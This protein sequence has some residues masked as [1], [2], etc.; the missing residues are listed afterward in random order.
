LNAVFIE[1]Y[2]AKNYLSKLPHVLLFNVQGNP[3][4][5]KTTIERTQ[6]MVLNRGGKNLQL[7]SKK[8]D[9]NLWD[10]INSNTQ[11][12]RVDF[13]CRLS[14]PKTCFGAAIDAIEQI[15]NNNR[16][17]PLAIHAHA[18]NGII[19]VFGSA[20]GEKEILPDQY[21]SQI[22]SLRQ[23]AQSSQGNLVVHSI[24]EEQLT[25]TPE[26]TTTSNV[27]IE[28]KFIW[29]NPGTEFQLMKAIKSKY[30]PGKVLATGRFI[31]GI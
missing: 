12:S 15:S 26:A 30:D 19:N 2:L 31:G 9:I 21:R 5:V 29:G 1:K 18:F 11:K 16:L 14:M 20:L 17:L 25:V 27:L 8:D 13:H 22:E 3:E 23:I 10:Q 7:F 24:A 6:Q 28:P 4:M